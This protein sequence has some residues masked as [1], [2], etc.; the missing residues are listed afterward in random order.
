MGK[1][2]EY[3]VDAKTSKTP[4]IKRVWIVG[5]VSSSMPLKLKGICS[6]Y[7]DGNEICFYLWM[8]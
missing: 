5:T 1:G 7:N 4:S 8:V 2:L 6:L 3:V